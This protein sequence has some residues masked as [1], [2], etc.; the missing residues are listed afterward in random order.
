M[1]EA[2]QVAPLVAVL[3]GGERTLAVETPDLL[4]DRLQPD[5]VFVDRPE[6]DLRV[7]EGG[8]DLPQERPELFLKA[9]CS[10]GSACTWRGRGLR[11]LPSRRTR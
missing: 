2:H 6:L 7:R 10:A 4:E 5:A 8:G 9:S 11:R 3:H 1:H